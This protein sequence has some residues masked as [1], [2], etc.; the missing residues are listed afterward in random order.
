[1]NITWF[2]TATISYTQDDRTIL[3]D[4]FLGWNTE[5]RCFAP[6]ELPDCNRIFITH[7]H[8]DHIL[9]A[10]GIIAK[11]KACISCSQTAAQHLKD[12]GVKRDRI[13]I[14]VPGQKI[15]EGPFT[16]RVLA[17]KHIVFDWPLIATTVFNVRMMRHVK[18]LLRILRASAKCKEG[19]SLVYD[20]ECGG[21]QMLHF[22]SFNLADGETYPEG[23]DVLIMPFQGRSDMGTYALAVAAKLKPKAVFLH[24]FDDAFP[25]ISRTV[26]TAEFVRQAAKAFP[27]MKIIVPKRGKEQS[28]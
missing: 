10:P 25:P 14:I 19:Q 15:E 2:G 18:N 5:L 12:L 8:F 13:N 24:H 9:D 7:G 27:S 17:G 22:G 11:G 28:L 16:I 3:F 20:I 23:A 1:L 6:G 21:R 4:P 26:D